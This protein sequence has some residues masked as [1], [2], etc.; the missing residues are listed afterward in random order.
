MTLIKKLFRY[1][2]HDTCVNYIELFEN[3]LSIFFGGGIYELDYSGRE[4][5]LTS[6]VEM[7]IIVDT[8]FFRLEEMI[9]VREIFPQYKRISVQEI[10]KTMF[11]HKMDINNV[12]YSSFN[13]TIMFDCTI[14]NTD[15]LIS[16]EE[17]VDINYV[18]GFSGVE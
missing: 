16:V 1:G 14:C 13:K 15:V 17:C 12:Y 3:R 9:E 4:V 11:N 2:F 8:R 5:K 7:Q 10:A 6:D 18:F